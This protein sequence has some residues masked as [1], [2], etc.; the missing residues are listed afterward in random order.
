MLKILIT[1]KSDE[2]SAA[3]SSAL[4][5]YEVH[6]CNT[7]TEALAML[8]T[9]HPDILIIDLVLPTTDGLTVLRES[10]F[11]PRIILALT[12]FISTTVLQAAADV[13]V[14]DIILIPCTISYIV[15]RLEA[16]I[17]KVPSLEV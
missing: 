15:N 6:I 4:N 2:I 11:R 16:L 5:Q 14:Q 1:T 9:L 10:C 3:L 17:E 12:N 7:G 8:E 13:G